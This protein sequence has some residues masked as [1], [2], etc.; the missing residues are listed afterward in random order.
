MIVSRAP[1]SARHLLHVFPSFAMG[2]SQARLIMLINNFGPQYRHSVISLNNDYSAAALLDHA[3]VAGSADTPSA[4]GGLVSRLRRY[5]S[6]ISE[7]VPELLLTYNWGAIEYAMANLPQLVTHIHV[8][9]GFGPQ[10]AQVRLARRSL[11][12]WAV[13]RANHSTLVVPSQSLLDIAR[14]EWRIPKRNTIRISNG[15]VASKYRR[16]DLRGRASKYARTADELVVGVVCGLRPEKALHRLIDAIAL[17]R[18]CHLLRLVIVGGGELEGALKAHCQVND[19]EQWVDF[20]GF[21][22]D[23]APVYAELDI[24]ALS[25]I[26]EQL[27][28]SIIEAMFSGLA[29]ASTDV[30]DIRTTLPPQQHGLLCGQ[31][32]NALAI[33]LQTLAASAHLRQSLARANA[34]RAHEAFS[35]E[36]M[37]AAWDAVF[38][39]G[40]G[41]ING[42]AP[43]DPR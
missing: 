35:A 43:V 10:E 25:S 30:G 39:C 26:T 31:D 38:R 27:P 21:V 14:N 1:E 24:F 42:A 18:H 19:Y 3:T 20:L 40:S 9:D 32:T 12:R 22:A 17:A 28:I 36:P 23:P 7:L 34:A 11:L 16:A 37:F 15:V 8:E 4:A 33:A 13:L 29:I 2:G 6:R 5:R 41:N